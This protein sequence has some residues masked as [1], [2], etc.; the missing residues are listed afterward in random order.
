MS[1]AMV[2][3]KPSYCGPRSGAVSDGAEHAL[4]MLVM[5]CCHRI[6]AAGVAAD[7]AGAAQHDQDL[8]I[9]SQLGRC[10]LA[11][12]GV[13]LI[14]LDREL[15]RMPEQLVADSAKGEFGAAFGIDTHRGVGAGHTQ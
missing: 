6:G 14:I 2:R 15:D 11:A 7:E 10:G 5:P 4:Q 3:P 9:G 8:R 1:L 12:L 13:A